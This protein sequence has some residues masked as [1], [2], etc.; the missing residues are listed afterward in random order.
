MSNHRAGPD[1]DPARGESTGQRAAPTIDELASMSH[2]ELER[3]G[4]GLDDTEIQLLTPAP[5]PGSIAEKRAERQVALC[6][7]L[8][9]VFALGFVVVFW[10]AGWFLPD[11]EYTIGGSLFGSL[12]TP[13]LGLTMGG[14]LLFLGIGLVLWIKKLMPHEVATQ[15]RH[16]GGSS[17][18]DA[19][20]AGGTILA[21][22][23]RTGFTRHKIVRRS[24]LGA[25]GALGLLAI[26][27]LGGLIKDP[28]R[29]AELFTTSWADGIRLVRDDGTPIRPSDMQPGSLETVFP[30]VEGG[31][32]QADA[33]TMLIRLRREQV[34]ELELPPGREDFV[35]Q[36]YVAYSKICTH[37][38]CPVSLYEQETGRI[39]CPCHQSQFLVDKGAKPVFGP[40]ARPLPQL[41]IDLDDEGFFVARGDYPEPVG[42]SF[43][44]REKGD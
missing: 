10:G 19:R 39:L 18:I 1:A 31:N 42:P 2:A 43:W 4:A 27:P 7:G 23:E 36:D 17:P 29:R 15:Q 33:A 9:T 41:P 44:N 32:R 25:A 16:D 6:F 5:P 34:A 28:N 40:A 24:L 22:F 26:M 35:Y 8:A 21:G 30:A 38:G 3:L 12:F 13:L 11:W 37:A 14:A 20:T